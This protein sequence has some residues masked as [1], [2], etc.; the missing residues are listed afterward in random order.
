MAYL[1]ML[2]F[3]S[4]PILRD[5]DLFTVFCPAD[6]IADSQSNSSES[7]YLLFANTSRVNGRT[8]YVGFR[9][10]EVNLTRLNC[11][12]KSANLAYLE[13]PVEP[14]STNVSGFT[15]NFYI[16]IFLSGC[17]FLNTETNTWQAD[18]L[19]ILGDSNITHTHC[20]AS[21]LTSFAGGFIVLPDAID[22]DAVWANASFRQ[23]SVI[24]SAVIGLVLVYVLLA[25]WACY[26]D[27]QDGS[28][29]GVSL[30]K[31]ADKSGDTQI[32]LENKYIYELVVFTGNR[33][34]AGTKSRVKCVLLSEES[35]TRE[36][37]LTDSKRQ[38]FKRGG[39]DSF[40]LL[41]N[42]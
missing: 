16:R 33:R 23:N 10:R 15:Q 35:R 31:Y 39:I 6:L 34:H 19:E 9:I 14:V 41:L 27:W 42:K 28:R 30:L 24:Y 40:I 12:N 32:S 25:V 13:E 21:H 3:G 37:E 11:A 17:Y 18:G 2:K 7:Y 8:G 36:I 22:F 4:N 1:A 38:V 20:L 5:Y 26:M 29:H